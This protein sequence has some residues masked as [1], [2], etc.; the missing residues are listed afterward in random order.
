MY[1]YSNVRNKNDLHI[2][3]CTILYTSY[4]LNLTTL[5]RTRV[6]KLTWKYS[7]LDYINATK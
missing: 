7:R 1:F 2:T 5:P 3:K 4:A 6:Y